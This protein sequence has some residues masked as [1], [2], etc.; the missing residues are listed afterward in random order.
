MQQSDNS[1]QFAPWAA[2]LGIAMLAGMFI[3]CVFTWIDDIRRPQL[4]HVT[5]PTAVGDSQF[6]KPAA[7]PQT[8]LGTFHGK[9]L[10]AA[11]KIKARDTEMLK[12]GMDD[13]QIFFI[14]RAQKPADSDARFVKTA[15]EEYLKIATP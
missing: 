1:L 4:E 3:V 12:A 10:I 2:R 9:P 6:V 7:D 14:Y 13:S 8:P 11:Q 5:Q 15:N